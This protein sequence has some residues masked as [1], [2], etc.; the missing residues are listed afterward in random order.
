MLLSDA[1]T[2]DWYRKAAEQGNVAAMYRLGVAYDT[3]VAV[4]HDAEQARAWFEKAAEGDVPVDDLSRRRSYTTF[5]R[6]AQARLSA[7]Y[8]KGEGGRLDFKQAIR[9]MRAA[10][11][12]V[13]SYEVGDS[14]AQD[15]ARHEIL[16]KADLTWIEARAGRDDADAEEFMGTVYDRGW[17][18]PVDQAKAFDWY[19]KAARKGNVNAELGLFWDYASGTGVTKDTAQALF[20]GEKAAARDRDAKVILAGALVDDGP[21]EFP[22]D[23]ARAMTLF[24]QGRAYRSLGVMYLRR[25]RLDVAKAK[26]YFQMAIDKGDV[27][28]V[29]NMAL[30][31]T[32]GSGGTKPDKIE[33]YRW[34]VRAGWSAREHGDLNAACDDH[35]LE[36]LVKSM[37]PEELRLAETDPRDR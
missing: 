17:G 7:M 27:G 20:W 36:P 19:L 24:E 10:L 1:T 13:D 35:D 31:Y 11:H 32:Q 26:S 23:E 28:A 33:G 2:P 18:R 21:P 37:T 16:E 4:H 9:R 8:R 3:G 6:L 15:K 14:P 29:C 25:A 12:D 5:Q 30:I 22:S 34:M